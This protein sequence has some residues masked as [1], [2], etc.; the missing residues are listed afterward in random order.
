MSDLDFIMDFFFGGG[1]GGG[2]IP[3]LNRYSM[4]LLLSMPMG[5][6]YIVIAFDMEVQLLVTNNIA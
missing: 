6:D 1:G 4:T 2:T 3:L 5:I